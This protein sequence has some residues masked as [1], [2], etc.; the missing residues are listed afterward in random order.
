MCTF[1][2]CYPIWRV[3]ILFVWNINSDVD[4]SIIKIISELVE[5]FHS[6]MDENDGKHK[7]NGVILM[8]VIFSHPVIH[9]DIIKMF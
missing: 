2:E 5:N 3:F 7:T 1:G 8:I 6:M 4:I 9:N